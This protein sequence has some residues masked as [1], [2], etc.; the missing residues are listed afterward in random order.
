MFAKSVLKTCLLLLTPLL[1]VSS[2]CGAEKAEP[3]ANPAAI[4]FEPGLPWLNVSRSLSLK[5]LRGKVVIL[6]FWTYGCINCIHVLEDF[7]KLEHKYGNKV[8]VIGIHT[9]KFD[10]EKNLDTLRRIVVR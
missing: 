10:N 8:V 1:L 9:P 7:R 6:D 5:D 3:T 2:A 4:P